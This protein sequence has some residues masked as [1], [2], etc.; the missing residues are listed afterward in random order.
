MSLLAVGSVAI[1]TVETPYG[2]ANEV[3]GGSAVYF[4]F[5]GGCFTPVR[6]VGAVGQDF[7]DE[8]RNLLEEGPIDLEGLEVRDGE[9]FRWDGSY[10]GTMAEAETRDV[11]LNVFED[12]RPEMPENFRDSDFVFL[13]NS[14]PNTQMHVLDQVNEPEFTLADTMNL[15]IANE[16]DALLELMGRIDGLILNDAE[17]RQLSERSNLLRAASWVCE[18]GPEYCIIK[19]GEH[20]SLLRGPEGIFVLPAYPAEIVKDPTGAGDSFAGGLMGYLAEQ[21]TV[22]F[23]T[24]KKAVAY[25]TIT[26]SFTIEDFSLN[27]LK[28]VSRDDIEERLEKLI[29][30]THLPRS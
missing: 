15:W 27:R 4:S 1:D 7:P 11:E 16:Q 8:F 29:E 21:G 10:E 3:L 26:S 30:Y 5:S 28:G 19:K 23:Q 20:G 22:D 25:G 24:L 14:D 18:H 9:T 13:A 6:L 2:K 12:F 17:A